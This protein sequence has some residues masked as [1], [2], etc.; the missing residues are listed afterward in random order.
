MA[1]RCNAGIKGVLPNVSVALFGGSRLSVLLAQ[2]LRP[3]LSSFARFASYI[4][5][6]AATDRSPGR[7]PRVGFTIRSRAPEGG[8]RTLRK[9]SIRPPATPLL[10]FFLITVSDLSAQTR[11]ALEPLI[12]SGLT[13]PLY[14]THAR[15]SS[16]RRFVVEQPGRISVIQPRTLARTLFLDI[17]SR[18]LSGG[19]R[20]LL[21]LAFH[22]QFSTNRRFFVNYTRRPDGATVVAE[23]TLDATDPNRAEPASETVLL[24]I[25]QPFANHNGGMIEFGPDGMLYIGMGDGGSGNDPEDNAQNPSSLLGKMLRLNLDRVQDGPV[26]HASGLRNPWRFSFDRVTGQ[27][28]AADVGQGAREEVDIIIESGNYGWSVFEGTRC[29]NLGRSS[30]IAE[31]Y[32]PP[33]TEYVNTGSGGRCSITGGYVYR[34]FQQ[35]LPDG[36][37][38]F[39]DYCSG[40]ILMYYNGTQSVLLDTTFAISSF[41]EDEAGEIYVIGHGGTVHRI[42]NPDITAGVARAFSVPNNGGSV[43]RTAGASS[44][45]LTGYARIQRDPDSTLPTGGLAIFSYRQSGILV[46]EA[47][48]S[49]S[50][51]IQSGR[52]YA[53][54]GGAANTG[55]AIANPNNQAVT[56]SFY[57]TD[58]SGNDF[59]Q[60]SISIPANQQIARFLNQ[61]P[62]NGGNSIRGTF[63]FSSSLAVSVV[64]LRGFTNERSEF[65]ITTLPVMNLGGAAG[66]GITFPHYADGGG[67]ITRV[68]LV[69]PTD[70]VMSGTAQFLDPLGQTRNSV[71][72][73]IAARSSADIS[74]SGTASTIQTG[75]VR[76]VPSAGSSTPSGLSIFT[77]RSGGVTVS[78]AG[79]QALRSSTAFRAYVENAGGVRSGIAVANPS[80]SPVVVSLSVT[81]LD[82][83]PTGLIGTLNIPANGQAGAFLNEI[84]GLSALPEGFQ[85][86]VRI[87]APSAVAVTSLRGR[88]NE[89]EDFL[90]TTTLPVDESETVTSSELLFPHFAE[91]A[92]YS[93][94]FVLFGTR[95]T[96]TTYFFNTFGQ[97]AGLSFR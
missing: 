7:Q 35:S 3:G 18:V 58:T 60:G 40:E 87:T 63:S 49:A 44:A 94:Q 33:V 32:I 22:P 48:V 47:S 93:M 42:T 80:S 68:V 69:N 27:L 23:Y 67:W 88:Q 36:A 46:S 53:E 11:V 41:G 1:R 30:C 66:E 95:S 79:V 74:T 64:A 96:G 19:E 24:V 56:V 76:I 91:G 57:F 90:I 59:G 16:G 55:I 12:T 8:G 84:P 29:T 89:R 65:L 72:Y 43:I 92:G 45:L 86:V 39:G 78:E 9:P 52:I 38:V 82:G 73:S 50:L 13:Q 75:S 2:G 31:N 20:G 97:P 17:T 85:G 54:V 62:F 5:R 71:S 28:W 51:L 83:S 15:D 77:F 10:L 34:G 21:G 14:L 70:A 4:S 37:Y 6:A 26:I 81:R 25:P 61:G